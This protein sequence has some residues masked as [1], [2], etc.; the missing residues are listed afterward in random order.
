ME[1][2]RT[3]AW[4]KWTTFVA[5]VAHTICHAGDAQHFPSTLIRV[6]QFQNTHEFWMQLNVAREMVTQ[7]DH[8]VLRSL[9]KYLQDEDRHQ[10]AN[11]AFVFAGLGD[12]RGFVVLTSI[13]ADRTDRGRGQCLCVYIGIH[14]ESGP[15]FNVQQQISADRNYATSLL[16]QLK[17]ARIPPILISLLE[18]PEVNYTAVWGLADSGDPR[19]VDPLIRT[20]NSTDPTLRVMAIRALAR[21]QAKDA[22][23]ALSRLLN[24]T[25]HSHVGDLISVADASR[26]ALA[27]LGAD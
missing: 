5:V 9:T 10:R 23:P 13:L 27:E 3:S 2:R 20:L 25:D 24:D 15:P 12:P 16:S 14:S 19:A 8:S 22:I 21:L 6:Q 18:D 11:A 26:E 17:D 4:V 7:K 1:H